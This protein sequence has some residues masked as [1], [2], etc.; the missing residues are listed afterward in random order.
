MEKSK[1]LKSKICIRKVKKMKKE[2]MKNCT[3]VCDQKFRG[4]VYDLLWADVRPHFQ[5]KIRSERTWSSNHSEFTSKNSH[6][7]NFKPIPFSKGPICFPQ[8]S[9]QNAVP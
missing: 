3:S 6:H 5:K 9:G 1:N 2:N 7:A 4:P 8:K